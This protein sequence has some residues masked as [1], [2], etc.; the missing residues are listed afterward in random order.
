[1]FTALELSDH[2][3]PSWGAD[4]VLYVTM[5]ILGAMPTLAL[6]FG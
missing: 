3:P 4:A 2:E 1:M 5:A 6:L